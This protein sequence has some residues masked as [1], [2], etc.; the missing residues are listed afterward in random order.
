M[1]AEQ[2]SDALHELILSHISDAVFITD[3]NGT[4]TFV[5]SN[6]N[7][8]FG[9]SRQ[10][11]QQFGNI[12]HLLG[13][14]LFEMHQLES[15]GELRNIQQEI[16]DKLG[17]SHH[18]LVNI[19]RVSI[20]EGAVLYTCRDI[21]E[22]Q[23]AKA[24]ISFLNAQL[25]EQVS[26]RTAELHQIYA[27]FTQEIQERQR[28]EDALRE[29][30]AQFRQ[31]AEKI[32]SVFW[33]VKP[34]LSELLYVSPMYEQI[35][36]RSC[37]SFYQNPYSWFETMHPEDRER[38]RANAEQAALSD[39]HQAELEIEYRIVRPDGSIRWIRARAFPIRDDAGTV[40]RVAGISDDIT[41]RKQAEIDRDRQTAQRQQVE[42][43]LKESELR[44]NTIVNSTSDGILIIDKQGIVRFANPSAA[45]LF[46]R[47]LEHLMNY[48]FGEPVLVGDVAELS[49][50]RSGGEIGIGE[51]SVAQT[52]WQGNPVYIVS[53]RD[54]TE[55]RQAEEALR[56]SE[57]RFRQLA[58]NIETV[59]WLFNP[60]TEEL[61]YISPAY[62]TL[63]GRTCES[64]Y[65]TAS[66]W[67]NTLYPE[68]REI[69]SASFAQQ[70]QGHSTHVEYR[71]IRP[72]GQI[73]WILARTFPIKNERHE[74]YRIAGIAEDITD[75][76][77]AQEA[78]RQSEERFRAIFENAGIGIAVVGTDL[79]LV[80][81][82]PF[83][84]QFI[85]YN[86]QELA[87]LDYTD[88]TYIE[89]SL[90]E[91]ALAQECMAGIR[92]GYCIEKR[93]IRKDGEIIWGNLTVSIIWD[94]AGQF[95]FAVGLIEDI[96]ERKQ[97]EAQ[98]QQYRDRLEELV[99]QRTAQ[100]QQEIIER[101]RAESAIHFQARLLDV[102]EHAIIA[103]DLSGV[104]IYWNRFAEQ[105]YGW[106]ATEAIGCNI[107]EITP[108]EASQEQA[109]EIMSCLSRGESW[110][111]EFW[112]QR[113]DG[114]LF[115]ALVTDSPIYDETG[116]LIGLVGISFDLTERKQAE[117]ALQKANAE[118]GIRVEERTRD[119]GSAIERL[120]QEI[121]RRK[122]VEDAL[123]ASQARFAGILE[124]ANDAIISIDAHQQITLFNQGAEKIFGYTPQE[125]LGQPV[126]L[127][128]PTRYADTHRQDVVNFAQS[129]G[130]ARRMRNRRE[131]WGRRKDGS[132]FPAEASISMLAMG[133]EKIFTAILRDIS[134]RKQAEEALQLQMNRE[135]LLAQISQHI[136]Q[137]LNLDQILNTTVHEVR[138]LLQSDRALIF[139]IELDKIG[140]VTHES[141]SPGWN[142]TVGN[143]YKYEEFPVD[144]YQSYCQGKA[145]I[146]TDITLDE[147]ASCLMKDMQELGVKS[148]LAVPILHSHAGLEARQNLALNM[149][150]SPLWGLLIIHQCSHIRSWQSWEVNLLQ[151]LA[152]QVA[153]AIQQAELYRQLELELNERK[154]AQAQLQQ[155]KEAAVSAAAQSAAANQ[156]KSEF[157]ANMS[158]ELRTPLNTILGFTQ[159]MSHERTSLGH[160]THSLSPQ[161]QEYLGI[162]NR[163][164]E[165]LLA[166]I[167]D[168]LSMSKIEAGRLTLDENSFDLYRLLDTL[169]KMF[170][171][172]AINQHLKLIFE[173]TVDVP[174]YIHTDE[175]KLRQVL[176]N[177]LGN[178]IKFTPSGQVMLR[179]VRELQAECWAVEPSN[180]SPHLQ[181]ATLRFE[182]EDTGTGIAPEEIDS[183]F[184]PF[185]QT[186]TGRKSQSGTGL[187]LAISQRFVRMMGGEITVSSVVGGGTIFKFDVRVSVAPSAQIF[188]QPLKAQVI[189]LAPDQ[190]R[191]RILVVEDQLTNRKLLTN[192]LE[193]LGFEV[194][195][196]QNGQEGV[197]LWESWKPHLIWMDIRMPV[198]DGYEATQ[199]IR[200]RERQQAA[201]GLNHLCGE[202]S[203]SYWATVIIAITASA[204]EEERER[205]LT[206]G[207]DDFVLKP[208]RAEIIFEKISQHLGVCYLYEHRD[209]TF[210]SQSVVPQPPLTPE[211]LA[212]M[213]ADWIVQLHQAARSLDAELMY[214]LIAQIPESHHS[215]AIALTDLIDDFRFDRMMELTQPTAL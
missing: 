86:S 125:V 152:T 90:I 8:I 3:S 57:E 14:N 115:P 156:A 39:Y 203:F 148:R 118:L 58:D 201:Q 159:L 48:D 52:E 208:F 128:M 163:S 26:D 211:A 105:L 25:E 16:T 62:E 30:E 10:E 172:K 130:E 18:L 67:V 78:L 154:Q 194:R 66:N 135:R 28:V 136:R 204:F 44:L 116:S 143:E 108:S 12:R 93:F 160:E 68:D 24:R 202:L 9:Y 158:H 92:N 213:P 144:C 50:I 100:L 170:Q 47:T 2:K 127:L 96:T 180:S 34:D 104:I 46:G 185:V 49:I 119:L 110:S 167:N 37:E 153:I 188:P 187:G 82:N 109:T 84:Q 174:Q 186:Q 75:R 43:Q 149:Q 98:L 70:L 111:G 33:M 205:F 145:R 63:W 206:A 76:K 184:N 169:E 55:R 121:V 77:Q 65:A 94:T 191:Y 176:I 56:E 133:G 189:A 79:K 40:Y 106:S 209:S 36:G 193:P 173:R 141:V 114:T 190:P 150:N 117:E 195:E 97:V 147:T 5:C 7:V 87:S 64:A 17:K 11:I 83:F 4:F 42:L 131:I 95:Q 165:H 207:C 178:A 112:V 61:L 21:T 103:T 181:P 171:L 35:W 1:D 123:R 182:V 126:S 88:I 72:D 161:Q 107:L 151:Q 175:S 140:I 38:I 89:D 69:A 53:L 124:I 183:L 22:H 134:E 23:Q 20:Q 85:G 120:Q 198:M 210:S 73:R 177:L 138:Q 139:R 212:V 41:E 19:K 142:S 6:A 164:G 27:Q 137:S 113:R 71:I 51:M 132:E 81:T 157:L 99:E 32:E 54:I 192:L 101:Q 122:Q 179:V 129:A 91:Q 199:Q 215:L 45:K 60:Y 196:A 13:E 168:I 155:A 146:I 59:F 102:V 214:K 200:A 74:V 162:I 80:Q 15:C 197:A 166:L 31:L 29:S